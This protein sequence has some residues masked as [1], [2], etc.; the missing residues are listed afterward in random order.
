MMCDPSASATLTVIGRFTCIR[1]MQL[2]GAFLV[3]LL[4]SL[5]LVEPRGSCVL[6]FCSV[7]QSFWN[8][9]FGWLVHVSHLLCSFGVFTS[10]YNFHCGWSVHLSPSLCSVVVFP[11]F[12]ASVTVIGPPTC[13]L[14]ST[15]IS[16][17]TRRIVLEHRCFECSL[18]ATK[19]QGLL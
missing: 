6:Q 18:L 15:A 2:W 10:F 16:R 5:W 12:F 19:C 3:F 4:R 9:Q 8:V 11:S 7:F 17:P 1:S 14:C 13:H